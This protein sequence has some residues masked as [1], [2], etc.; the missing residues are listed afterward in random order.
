MVQ[1]EDMWAE[2]QM[3]LNDKQGNDWEGHRTNMH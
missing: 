3:C 1:Q 2:Y